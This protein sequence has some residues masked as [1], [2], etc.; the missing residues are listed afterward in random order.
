MNFAERI[1][2]D[3]IEGFVFRSQSST[4]AD[5]IAPV[6]GK[7]V[8]Q[9]L[10]Q[11]VP[12]EEAPGE[13]NPLPRYVARSTVGEDADDNEPVLKRPANS[14]SL[15]RGV[16]DA[17]TTRSSDPGDSPSFTADDTAPTFDTLET[18]AEG[19][20]MTVR[21][22]LAH[23]PRKLDQFIDILLGFQGGM[24]DTVEVMQHVSNLLAG[25][26]ELI[27]Q[28]NEFLPEG[29]VIEALPPNL[30]SYKC[31]YSTLALPSAA[32]VQLLASCFVDRLESRFEQSPEKLVTFLQAVETSK[33]QDQM[34]M[35]GPTSNSRLPIGCMK[36]LE[37]V[38]P[39]M[40]D[41]P[42]LMQ[43]LLQYMPYLS[44]SNGH[45]HVVA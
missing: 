17:A 29:Y 16:P 23:Q 39:L 33:L 3:V 19:L 2:T 40:E 30:A 34:A 43:E 37:T 4:A 26:F 9:P 13:Q 45:T 22:T 41:E 25:H 10:R 21:E 1:D 18:E 44:T 5:H 42:D 6:P 7:S 31:C 28:F 20:V 38:R 12:Q 8:V 27:K 11:P 32:K 35:F 15:R 36:V 24:L 14:G